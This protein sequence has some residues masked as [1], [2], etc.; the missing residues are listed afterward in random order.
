MK[1]KHPVEIPFQLQMIV[2]GMK[3]KKETDHIRGNYRLRLESIKDVLNKA[4]D[5]F[6]AEM[7]SYNT[8]AKR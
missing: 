4:C 2:D 3:N 7:S 1:T 8:S 6:D 5:E